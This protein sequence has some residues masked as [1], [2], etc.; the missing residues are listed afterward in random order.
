MPS[1]TSKFLCKRYYP[2]TGN[3]IK[4]IIII[5]IKGTTSIK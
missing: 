5:I 1:N 4:I 3:S 2:R